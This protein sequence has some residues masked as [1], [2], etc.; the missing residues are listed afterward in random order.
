MF[1]PASCV[2]SIEGC[3]CEV[4][5]NGNILQPVN[6]ITSLSF[7]VLAIILL[8]KIAKSPTNKTFSLFYIIAL[9]VVGLG[10]AYY[11]L[12]FDMLGQT[13]DFL[14]MYLLLITG[15]VFCNL[16]L[17]N[18]KLKII[19]YLMSVGLVVLSLIY[20]P[21]MRRY[22]FGIAVV[23][24]LITEFQKRYKN[25][26]YLKIGLTIFV[27]SF[28]LW[29]FDNFKIICFQSALLNF[30]AWWHILD[31]IAAYFLYLHYINQNKE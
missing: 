18:I 8:I 4:F 28:I 7:V 25:N 22:L 30:H 16:K 15:P 10:S 9:F 5:Q 1:G 2:S 19:Y 24:L 13:L 23:F 29:I 14:G 21:E 12:K 20:I 26:R 17:D 27:F 11:H 31:A 6:A 3:F